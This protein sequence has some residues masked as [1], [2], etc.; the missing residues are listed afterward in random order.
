M[1]TTQL[2]RVLE[3]D[4]RTRSIFQ[5]VFPRNHIPP[6]PHPP[7]GYVLNTD[8]CDRP[9]E[10]WV[11]VFLD[12][13]GQGEYFDSYGLPP[14]SP[15]ITRWLTE[16]TR[17]WTWNPQTLQSDSTAVCGQY[18]LYYALQRARDVPMSQIVSL[19]EGPPSDNDVMVYDVIGHA[20]SIDAPFWVSEL[21]S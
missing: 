6:H 17:R 4:P 11:V 13:D 8:P 15:R 12:R 9:G 21:N 18:C 1:N 19:F 16:T 20:F 14:V 7:V 2:Q 5:G 3:E 10:H